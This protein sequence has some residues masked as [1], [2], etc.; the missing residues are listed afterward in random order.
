MVTPM[1]DL[2]AGI[3]GYASEL[4]DCHVDAGAGEF[5]MGVTPIEDREE[6]PGSQCLKA[7]GDSCGAEFVCLQVV[8][9]PSALAVRVTGRASYPSPSGEERGNSMSPYS[10]SFRF[11]I[12]I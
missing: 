5:T 12:R 7:P 9:F 1:R 6:R 2:Q 3:D 4:V 11:V 8:I 10:V